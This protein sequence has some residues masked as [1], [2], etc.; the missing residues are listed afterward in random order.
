MKIHS[1][2]NVLL[3]AS[4]CKA[5]IPHGRLSRRVTNSPLCAERIAEK[6]LQSP[7]WPAEWPYTEQDLSRMDES[8]DTVFY[9]SPRLVY[10]I[11]DAAVTA[12]TDYYGKNLKEGE[13]VLDICSS[14]VSHFPADWKGASPLLIFL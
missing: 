10:H 1:L 4:S 3:L 12:L 14:W 6:V 9:E 5:F 11:D 7:Q 13:D 8:T 2:Q